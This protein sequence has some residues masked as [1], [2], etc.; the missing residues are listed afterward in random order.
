LALRLA[1]Q[2]IDR[3]LALPLEAGLMEEISH[4]TEIFSSEDAR[5][6]LASIGQAAPKFL[7]R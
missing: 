7:G 5:I 4:L 3:G 1:E 2:I 6:G